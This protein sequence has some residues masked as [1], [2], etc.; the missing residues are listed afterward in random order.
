MD[1]RFAAASQLAAA[2]RR[3]E[4]SPVELMRWTLARLAQVNPQL[5][6]FVALR[7]EEELL[8]EAQAVAER[9]A[10]GDEVGPLAGLPLGVK[11]LEDVAGLPNT[12]GSLIYR[13]NIS[14]RDTIQVQ[15]LKRAGA[16][17]I[18][19]T[20]TPE[21]GYTAFTTNR[22]FGPTRNPWNLE[23]T[24]GGSSGGSAAA[25]AGGMVAL[26][27]A[28]DGGGSVRIPA[29]YTGLVGLKP[30]QGRI[31]WGPE[32][33]LR[34]SHCIVSGPLARTVEDAALWLDVTVGPHPDD[35]Y[36]L[37]HPGIS[38]R[39][40]IRQPLPRLRI[41]YSAT[42]GYA[43]PARAVQQEVERAL[44]ALAAAG[45]RIEPV[46]L[47]LSDIV[48]DWA[49]LMAMEDY[50]F[51]GANF[52]DEELL[53]PGYRVGV[54]LARHLKPADLG[55]V[56]RLRAELNATI[57][58][59]FERFDLLATP[60]TATEA[61]AAEG[62]IPFE[63]D[64]EPVATPGGGIAY[65]YPFNFTGHPAISLRAGLTAERLP[66]GIQF[67]GPRLREDLLLQLAAEYEQLRPWHEEWP[68][69]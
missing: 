24:P 33:A 63:V 22:L 61:F 59:I 49:K 47:S 28:S 67:V 12:H 8:Q 42:L 40:A 21:F 65:T 23:R 7:N 20:N 60:T 29:A 31:P 56:L 4:L 16:I 35:P 68:E 30:C 18:G 2:I 39:E 38:Y 48:L 57:S 66:V 9:L 55:E 34:V 54:E 32:S 25:I 13:D 69:L 62:P 50:A 27:T 41:A 64:G 11:D 37:P 44:A 1:L 14:T 51:H 17:V 46:E 53:D 45:H 10:R 36:S 26:A 5:N 19:K 6:A 58:R 3:K 15:R 43:R 52:H